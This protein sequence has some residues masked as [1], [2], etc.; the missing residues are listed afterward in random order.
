MIA[1]LDFGDRHIVVTGGS[2]ALGAAVE[3]SVTCTQLS[4][5]VSSA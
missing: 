4:W 2:G 3:P 1:I 5:C